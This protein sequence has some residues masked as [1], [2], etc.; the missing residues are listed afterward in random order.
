MEYYNEEKY[1]RAKKKVKDIKDFYK[2][3]T[4]Y[5]IINSILIIINLG[6]FQSGFSN[7]KI[8]TWPM[9]TTPFFWGIGLLFHGLHVFHKDFGLFKKWENRKMKEYMEKEEEDNFRNNFKNK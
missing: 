4:I 3:L 5:L 2:H 1:N 8:P 6:V 9:F 7:I